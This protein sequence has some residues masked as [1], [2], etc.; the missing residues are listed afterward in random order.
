MGSFE[1]TEVGLRGSDL[2]LRLLTLIDGGRVGK[3]NP[4]D[5][6]ELGSKR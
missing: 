2:H 3:S 6:E 1:E 5:R 4:E